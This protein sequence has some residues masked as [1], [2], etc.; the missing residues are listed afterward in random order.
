MRK[1][2]AMIGMPVICRSRK[3]GRMIQVDITDDLKQMNGIWVD[4]GL[5]GTRYIPSESLE[6]LGR[7]AIMADDCG[8]RKRLTSSPIF[9]RAVSTDGRRLGAIT[10][11]E[12]NELSFAVESLELSGGIWDDLFSRRERI[13]HYTVNRETGEVI[14]EKAGEE[15]EDETDEERYDEGPDHGPADRRFRGDDFRRDELADGEE[16]EHEGQENR[17]LDHQQSR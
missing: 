12:I 15:M 1:V 14:V 10:G 8:K 4:A 7:V 17:Q 5:R 16:V 9:H 3:I 13:L 11:A 6:M 2:R